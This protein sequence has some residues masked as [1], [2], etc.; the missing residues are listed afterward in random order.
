MYGLLPTTHTNVVPFRERQPKGD[1]TF[2]DLRNFKTSEGEAARSFT[3]QHK[4]SRNIYYSSRLPSTGRNKM[5]QV[6]ILAA[7]EA[8]DDSEIESVH[9]QDYM[10][11]I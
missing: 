9:H 8:S 11:G 3:H 6:N 4:P 2:E 7:G 5:E 1:V 10:I